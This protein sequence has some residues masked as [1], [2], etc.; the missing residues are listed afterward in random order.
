MTSIHIC[1]IHYFQHERWT[2]W[3]LTAGILIRIAEAAF[4]EKAAFDV[5]GPYI[6]YA[7]LYSADGQTIALR[8]RSPRTPR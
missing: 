3:G 1:R 7:Q 4:G 6:D 2:V 5:T 8:R